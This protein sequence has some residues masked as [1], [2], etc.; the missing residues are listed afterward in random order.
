M[1]AMMVNDNDDHDDNDDNEDDEKEDD[2]N[3]PEVKSEGG[4]LVLLPTEVPVI[5]GAQL[6][7]VELTSNFHPKKRS[8]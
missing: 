2:G 7:V 3:H 8:S 1:T 6:L 4:F 5:V